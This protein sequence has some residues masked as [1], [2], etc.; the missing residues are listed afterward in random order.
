MPFGVIGLVIGLL[1]WLFLVVMPHSRPVDG[2]RK[3][4]ERAAACGYSSKDTIPVRVLPQYR[5]RVLDFYHALQSHDHL[6]EVNGKHEH[7]HSAALRCARGELTQP[8]RQHHKTMV[9]K[10]NLS[11]HEGKATL[12]EPLAPVAA[13]VMNS[14]SD[15]VL[16]AWADAAQGSWG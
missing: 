1:A 12:P 6:D 16:V 8:Q 14:R 9:Q 10:G 7:N 11:R 5:K 2:W 3:Q 15:D 13:G 4:A